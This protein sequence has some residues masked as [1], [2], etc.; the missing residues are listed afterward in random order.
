MLPVTLS[1]VIQDFQD[2]VRKYDCYPLLLPWQPL[3]FRYALE[4][5]P[6][7]CYC[8]PRSFKNFNIY[9][10]NLL[11]TCYCCHGNLYIFDMLSKICL[12][13]VT[14]NN[15]RSRFSTYSSKICLLPV[16]MAIFTFLI[17]SRKSA[18]YLL[19]RSTVI[20][21][22][23]HRLWKSPCYLLPVTA[24][25]GQIKLS[26]LINSRLLLSRSRT[27]NSLFCNTIIYSCLCGSLLSML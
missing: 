3:H 2:T 27:S 12:L 24:V 4:N 25:H 10:Q 21:D 16:T 14:A 8:G 17:C 18:C 1:T 13:P 9:F 6:V 22:F 20:Q 26:M 23:Q 5:L 11:V 7:T 19:L 15:G